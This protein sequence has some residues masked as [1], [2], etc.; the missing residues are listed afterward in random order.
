MTAMRS[1]RVLSCGTVISGL[2]RQHGHGVCRS[3]HADGGAAAAGPFPDNAP[4]PGQHLKNVFYRMG[5]GDMEIVALSGAHTLGRAKPSR[6]GFGQ[7]ATKYTKDGPGTPGAS[8][9][10]CLSGADFCPPVM[11]DG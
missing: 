2:S 5:L 8:D 3:P 7:E 4:T 6:S 9:A 10:P 11:G 1:S